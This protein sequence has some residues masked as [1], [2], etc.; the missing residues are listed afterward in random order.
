MNT[1]LVRRP[2]TERTLIAIA[3]CLLGA[4]ILNAAQPQ[5]LPV[6][7]DP[8]AMLSRAEQNEWL[9]GRNADGQPNSPA[10]W[11]AALNARAKSLREAGILPTDADI[12]LTSPAEVE[13]F[14]AE[15]YYDWSDAHANASWQSRLL[16]AATFFQC[17]DAE[18][19]NALAAA[20]LD[21]YAQGC[22]LCSAGMLTTMS[23][24]LRNCATPDYLEL[25]AIADD[26]IAEATQWAMANDQPHMLEFIADEQER[27]QK[28]TPVAEPSPSAPVKNEAETES[29]DPTE[30][31]HDIQA[32][33]SHPPTTMPSSNPSDAPAGDLASRILAVARRKPIDVAAWTILFDDATRSLQKSEA[34]D[35]SGVLRAL[36][37]T[38]IALRRTERLDATVATP[39]E[40]WLLRLAQ[41]PTW[42]R[43][44]AFR[45]AWARCVAML[46]GSASE[47]FRRKLA[48]LSASA[49]LRDWRKTLETAARQLESPADKK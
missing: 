13:R 3:L 30:D 27:M 12:R 45:R 11:R 32:I 1:K 49:E 46:R 25:D 22:G 47:T 5:R 44:A 4:R 8:L 21:L 24:A 23:S 35:P 36:R 19:A 43:S 42:T 29:L 31:A 34:K 10:P 18:T 38:S 14:V 39:V 9:R 33:N 26:L 17:A 20:L 28:R 16:D 40:F 48:E 15:F 6:A 2:L 37:A 7:V 41:E